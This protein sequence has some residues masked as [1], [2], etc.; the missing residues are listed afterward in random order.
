MSEND[1]RNA[2]AQQR[3]RNAAVH[4]DRNSAAKNERAAFDNIGLTKRN[5]DYL[6]RF[7]QALEA[8]Q[9]TTEKKAEIVKQ[10][11][12]ELLEGQ[13]T[14]KTARN[15]YGSDIDARIKE[16][17]EGP[18][19]PAGATDPYWP[20]VLYN[21]M[22]FFTMFCFMFGLMFLFAPASQKDNQAVGM[23]SI[24][25]SS[26]IAGLALPI[27][28]RAFDAK[29]EHKYSLWIRVLSALAFLVLWL[30]LFTLTSML[31]SYLNP[32]I[33]AWPMLIVGVFGALTSFVVKSHYK[34]TQ[35]FFGSTAPTRRK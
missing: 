19:R 18:K 25:L 34:L 33:G 4:Q 20:S 12:S 24:I 22:N 29:R 2:S 6:F 23:F 35:G 13:K 10:T 30:L 8:T 14:G 27:I 21:G 5:A 32:A 17:V 11:T 3:Q 31:P 1:K 9:L 28:P 26:V 7:N 16:I 15:L